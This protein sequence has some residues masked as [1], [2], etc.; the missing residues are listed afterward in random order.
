MKKNN[1]AVF[2]LGFLLIEPVMA[3]DRMYCEANLN[4]WIVTVN[5]SSKSAILTPLVRSKTLLER[6]SNRLFIKD[7]QNNLVVTIFPWNSL[8]VRKSATFSDKYTLKNSE[9]N[10]GFTVEIIEKKT[11]KTRSLSCR[12][13]F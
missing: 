9:N 6:D 5:E 13:T 1:V 10:L 3:F 7:D 8:Y 12:F 2:I 4:D 11:A